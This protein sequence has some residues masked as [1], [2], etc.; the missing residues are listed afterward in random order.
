[1]SSY[2]ER[3]LVLSI[4]MILKYP[5]KNNLA[6]SVKAYG[7]KPLLG[8]TIVLMTDLVETYHTLFRFNTSFKPE[9][10]GVICR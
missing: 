8:L 7:E 6:P 9:N 3:H 4:L 10:G 1:M 5:A 2:L